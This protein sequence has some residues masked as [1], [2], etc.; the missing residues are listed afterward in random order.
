[1]TTK[2]AIAPAPALHVV[3]PLIGNESWD[4]DT[5]ANVQNELAFI[6]HGLNTGSNTL[7]H[8]TAEGASHLILCCVAA[9]EVTKN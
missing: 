7:S 3:N 8:E 9:I 2:Q 1:M 4:E 5:G 6:A